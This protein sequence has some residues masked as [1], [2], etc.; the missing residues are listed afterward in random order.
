M[1]ETITVLYGSRQVKYPAWQFADDFSQMW[2]DHHAHQAWSAGIRA[3]MAIRLTL[4]ADKAAEA[5]REAFRH[6][7]K[8]LE[9]RERRAARD[10]RIRPQYVE[11]AV[12]GA[13]GADGYCYSDADPGM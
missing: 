8:A 13:I 5:A 9:C 10:A 6:A 7:A 4:D 3:R 2:E 12:S 1:S 11:S